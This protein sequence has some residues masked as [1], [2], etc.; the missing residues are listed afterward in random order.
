MANSSEELVLRISGDSAGGQQA[1]QAFAGRV[2]ALTKGMTAA[3]KTASASGQLILGMGQAGTEA[4]KA[5]GTL[6]AKIDQLTAG[7]TKSG[8]AATASGKLIAGMGQSGQAAAAALET[9]TK[10]GGGLGSMLT[11]V[12][13]LLGALGIGMG[14]GAAVNFGKA[15]LDDADS[16]VKLSDKTGISLQGLQK[17]QIAGDDA[18]NT[19]DQLSSAVSQMQNR[20]AGGDASAVGALTKLHLS[21][22]QLKTLAPDQQFMSIADAIRGI[23][24]PADQ[25]N[26]AM[27]IFGRQGAEILPTIKRGFDDLKDASVGMSDETIKNLDA[28][29]DAWDRYSRKAKGVLAD[30]AVNMFTGDRVAKE[31]EAQ[32]NLANSYH[33]TAQELAELNAPQAKY[34]ANIKAAKLSDEELAAIDKRLNSQLSLSVF[35]NQQAAEAKRK[36][37]ATVA[38]ALKVEADAWEWLQKKQGDVMEETSKALQRGAEGQ[39]NF[40]KKWQAMQFLMEQTAGTVRLDSHSFG[41]G[42]SATS[43]F[44]PGLGMTTLGAGGG[45]GIGNAMQSDLQR[46]PGLVT[47]AFTGGGGVKGAALGAGSMIGSTIGDT[48]GKTISSMGKLGGPILGAI[49]SLAGPLIAKLFSIGG[50]S[51]EELAARTSQSGLIDQ[52]KS[53]V[54]QG[55]ITEGALTDN[56]HTI[57]IVARDAFIKSGLSATDAEKKIAGLLDTKHPDAFKRAM[58]ELNKVIGANVEKQEQLTKLLGN[59]DEA[60]AG[61]NSAMEKWNITIGQMGPAF[62]QQNL[63]VLAG[64]LL[65]DFTLLT[66][67][68]GDNVQV[69]DH[70]KGGFQDLVTQSLKTGSTIPENL[71]PALQTLIDMGGLTDEAGTKLTDI[72]QLNFGKTLDTKFDSLIDKIGDLV[73]ALNY[74]L[75][76][77]IKN[78]PDKTVHIGVVTDAIPSELLPSAALP[79]GRAIP[80]AAGGSFHVTTPTMFLA[81]EKPGGED[82]SF[83][84]VGKSFGRWSNGPTPVQLVVSGR[85]LAEVMIPELPGAAARLGATT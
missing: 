79:R 16:L 74:D 68:G 50:P 64:G 73:D 26:V 21:L 4:A 41:P 42:S 32:V 52:L 69:L 45:L 17:F 48:I 35:N 49:G 29:G 11:K 65:K 23:K 39:S 10:S 36:Y 18:G 7:M 12:N 66:A 75:T 57:A 37:A 80:M 2:D 55:E 22:S 72:S 30:L 14:V 47:Q 82:V 59:E 27:D 77:A 1:M 8:Q 53:M 70:M 3:G 62:K 83:S 33:F 71:K 5:T 85:V 38:A 20:L 54:T 15:M 63:D 6:V 13:P 51:K 60:T 43:P 56:Y 9:T 24:D 46:L 81:G 61:V 34:I 25:V 76:G 84:G 67:A 31:V 78:L 28:A 40:M 44:I 58:E 19:V